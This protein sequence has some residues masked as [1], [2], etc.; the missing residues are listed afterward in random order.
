MSTIIKAADRNLAVQHVAFNFDDMAAGANQYLDR[1]RKEAAALVLKAQKQAAEIR[2]Q[3]E[4][5]GRRQGLEAV[6]AMVRQRV[7]EQLDTLMPALGKVIGD[8]QDAKQSWLVHW[9]KSALGVASAIAE[10]LIRRELSQEPQITLAL[11]REALELAAGSSRLRIHLNP[12]D[13]DTLAPDVESLVQELAGLADAEIVSDPQI[14]PGGC[15][16]ETA[17][18]TIDQQF[19]AQLA[20]IQEELT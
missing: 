20:R 17:F 19:E 15:R 10:R 12:A 2:T 5:E 1:V 14:S 3:A 9:E 4:Q 16:V 6:E 18:G 8:V 7:T 11:I 13:R